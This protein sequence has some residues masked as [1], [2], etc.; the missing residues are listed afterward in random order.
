MHCRTGDV[1]VWRATRF[2]DVLGDITVGTGGLHSGLVFV[3]KE[4]AALSE[5]GP[6]PSD[7]Y[8]TFFI[9]KVYPIEEVLGHIW[10]SGNGAALYHIRRVDGANVQ[11]SEAK[12][13][14]CETLDLKPRSRLHTAYIAVA[15]Y[16][17]WGAVAPVT[18]QDNSRW[19]MCSTLATYLL[20]RM[21]LLIDQCTPNNVLPH[22]FYEL[23]FYQRDTYERVTIFDKETYRLDW[24]LC[25]FFIQTGQLRPPEIRCAI[26]DKMLE[27]YDYPRVDAR[28][29]CPR[30]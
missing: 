28:R 8:V 6:S 25:A 30:C 5:C 4:F 17:R 10:T 21:G 13:I 2:Y 23:R 14:L 24:W 26:V 1:L 12:K 22:D 27:K 29:A 9:D 7:T 3:G 18:G 16:F 11:E 15:G 19:Q 20:Y